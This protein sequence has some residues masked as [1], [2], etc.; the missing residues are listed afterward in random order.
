MNASPCRGHGSSIFDSDA[1]AAAATAV[2][3]RVWC[4]PM[5]CKKCC[6]LFVSG[7]HRVIFLLIVWPRARTRTR[8]VCAPSA[9]APAVVLF[10]FQSKRASES[11]TYVVVSPHTHTPF[12]TTLQTKKTMTATTSVLV[13]EQCARRPRVVL[14]SRLAADG[15]GFVEALTALLSDTD[16]RSCLLRLYTTNAADT[17]SSASGAVANHALLKFIG[18]RAQRTLFDGAPPLTGSVAAA[19][20]VASP[21]P[22]PSEGGDD[23]EWLPVDLDVRRFEALTRALV[24]AARERDGATSSR[25]RRPSRAEAD[26]AEL[27]NA[28]HGTFVYA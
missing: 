10:C 28:P 12:Q 1:A 13:F 23:A 4:A 3:V 7:I 14:A 2:A 17:S 19:L 24:D 6:R 8:T 25:S 22:S 21:S 26:A 18:V 15:F 27:I 16:G 5:F 20:F 11:C 9:R